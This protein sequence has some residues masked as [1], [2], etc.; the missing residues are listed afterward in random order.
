MIDMNEFNLYLDGIKPAVLV[1][2]VRRKDF[3]ELQKKVSENRTLN[4]FTKN[5][6]HGS[7]VFA[8]KPIPDN[9]NNEELGLFLGYP[10]KACKKF[11]DTS[12][13]D[14]SLVSNEQ[15][16]F[17]NYGGLKFTS[18]PETIAEDLIWLKERYPEIECYPKIDSINTFT[19]GK[20]VSRVEF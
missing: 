2:L 6:G 11:G 12:I 1:N 19:N 8:D 9:M 3:E 15:L 20:F 13:K 16:L 18:Y 4:Y 14:W 10:P 17:V 7:I 5:I